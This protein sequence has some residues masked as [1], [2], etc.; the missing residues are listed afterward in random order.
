MDTPSRI[1]FDNL[2]STITPVRTHLS[3][4]HPF[5][6]P[7]TSQSTY[8]TR[9]PSISR[10]HYHFPHIPLPSNPSTPL[11]NLHSNSH[12]MPTSSSTFFTTADSTFTPTNT[13]RYYQKPS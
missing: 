11:P 9:L 7:S 4:T 2:H 5:I 3:P 12:T 6:S 1:P 13:P 8:A 10:T